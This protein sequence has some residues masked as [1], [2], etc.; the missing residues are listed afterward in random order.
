MRFDL[1]FVLGYGDQDLRDAMA[2]VVFDDVADYQ[3]GKKHSHAR[4][5]KVEDIIRGAVE[6]RC[7]KMPY[8]GD[9][10]L[11]DDGGKSAADAHGKGKDYEPV[12]LRNPCKPLPQR[13]K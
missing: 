4:I 9:K 7:E 12:A 2:D 8:Q 11:E 3:Q 13:G 1:A 6:P 5:D 10:L